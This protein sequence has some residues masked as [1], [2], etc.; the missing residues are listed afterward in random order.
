[1]GQ[2]RNRKT[3]SEHAARKDLMIL[4]VTTVI[5]NT[6]TPLSRSIPAYG[7][8]AVKGRRKLRLRIGAAR[9]LSAVQTAKFSCNK[10]S[11]IGV[12]A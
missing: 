5:W 2:A 7:A 6:Y 1:M 11:Q 3:G 10:F 4:K 12:F 9:R 8:G